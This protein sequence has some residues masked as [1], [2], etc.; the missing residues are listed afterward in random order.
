VQCGHSDPLT[1]FGTTKVAAPDLVSALTLVR[2]TLLHALWTYTAH[3]C[4]PR[5]LYRVNP[6]A[7]RG[8]EA[9]LG[10]I[11]PR[12]LGH[13]LVPSGLLRVALLI[14]EMPT[15]SVS[16]RQLSVWGGTGEPPKKSSRHSTLAI[17]RPR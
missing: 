8:T 16:R 13:N 6:A 14:S 5:L 15:R 11:T 7:T 2:N 1:T 10:A 17:T 12:R 3:M 9:G 4:R